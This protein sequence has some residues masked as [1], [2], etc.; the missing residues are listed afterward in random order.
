MGGRPGTKVGE[1]T[2][3]RHFRHK[4]CEAQTLP[5]ATAEQCHACRYCFRCEHYGTCDLRDEER[6]WGQGD[7]PACEPK[8]EQCTWY[9]YGDGDKDGDGGDHCGS[10][11]CCAAMAI[12]HADLSTDGNNTFVSQCFEYDT[13]NTEPFDDDRV[14]IKNC[15]LCADAVRTR[16]GPTCNDGQPAGEGCSHCQNLL[17]A[18]ARDCNDNV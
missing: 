2:V 12:T 11:E 10:P 7:Y 4:P 14:T 15:S 17:D 18:L 6:C 1:H 5:D 13:R 3:C 16:F 8:W 9:N